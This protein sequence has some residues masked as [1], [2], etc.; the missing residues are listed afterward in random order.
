MF[1]GR[2]SRGRYA[3]AAAIR[4]GLFVAATLAFPLLLYAIIKSSNCGGIGGACGALALVVSFYFKPPL[5]L[6]FVIS[7]IGI[8]VRRVR[9]VGLP[10]AL[11]AAVPVLMLGDVMFGMTFGAPWSLAFSFGVVK[12]FPTYLIMAL[13]CIGFLCVAPSSD[14]AA[15]GEAGGGERRWGGAGALAFGIVVLSSLSAL[16]ALAR[17]VAFL[18]ISPSSVQFMTYVIMYV[19]LSMSPVLLFAMF[20]LIVRQQRR[21]PSAA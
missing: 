14:E 9:D 12:K 8:T 5:Y 20:V 17:E 1:A 19:T 10:V 7:F 16:T 6:I 21:R 2:L 18:F 4:I 13:M 3:R 11:A 15:S